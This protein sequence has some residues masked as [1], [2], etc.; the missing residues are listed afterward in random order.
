MNGREISVADEEEHNWRLENENESD[1]Y[2]ENDEENDEINNV[3]ENINDDA[4]A[5]PQHY[6]ENVDTFLNRPPPKLKTITTKGNDVDSKASISLPK[7]R[8]QKEELQRQLRMNPGNVKKSAN[9]KTNDVQRP[10][11]EDLLREAMEYTKKLVRENMIDDIEGDS[12]RVAI[13]GGSA[14]SRIYDTTEIYTEV[15]NTRLRRGSISD[16][17]NK[18]K[19]TNKSK[20]GL[21]NNL[22]KQTQKFASPAVT[23]FK[24]NKEPEED[25][26]RVTIDF[27]ALVA[28]FESG[29]TLRKLQ[30]ELEESKQSMK[31]SQEALKKISQDYSKQLRR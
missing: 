24:T 31:M 8:Q 21:V 2:C 18:K 6:Y 23:E 5:M 15:P 22:R 11:N 25:L 30:A 13:T 10:F 7:L 17:S 12:D 26:R 9:K 1:N 20:K 3:L 19:N 27:D 16:I 29:L 14:P 4:P 28:N